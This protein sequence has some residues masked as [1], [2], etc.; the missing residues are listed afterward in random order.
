MSELELPVVDREQGIIIKSVN[1]DS[2]SVGSG[3]YVHIIPDKDDKKYG[4]WRQADKLTKW[5]DEELIK[6]PEE[7]IPDEPDE[8]YVKGVMS[9]MLLE[10][11]LSACEKCEKC[12]PAGKLVT[13]TGSYVATICEE[14]E[15][16]CSEC[17]ADDWESLGKKRK[18]SATSAPRWECNECGHVKKGITTG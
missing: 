14:C 1:V 11:G 18:N 7:K 16:G 6:L 5:C 17:G 3:W 9:E 13:K 2:Y 12:V 4:R 15:G 10:N 8:K